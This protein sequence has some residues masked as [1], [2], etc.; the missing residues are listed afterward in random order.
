MCKDRK[1]EFTFTDTHFEQGL[2]KVQSGCEGQVD[3]PAQQV[4]FYCHL[5]N[6]QGPGEVICQVILK[7]VI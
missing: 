3:F 2:K 7:K 1:L 5:P 4:T 6:G